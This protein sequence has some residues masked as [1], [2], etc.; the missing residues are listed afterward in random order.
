[1]HGT[2]PS[3]FEFH[4]LIPNSFVRQYVVPENNHY[5]TV[6]DFDLPLH[7]AAISP[8]GSKA[9]CLSKLV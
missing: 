1:M 8:I 7:D 6:D 4:L 5:K 9:T 2:S 3:C